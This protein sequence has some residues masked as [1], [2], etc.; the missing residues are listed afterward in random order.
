MSAKLRP[1]IVAESGASREK[2]KD[3]K[4]IDEEIETQ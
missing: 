4:E 2:V 3:V 1:E